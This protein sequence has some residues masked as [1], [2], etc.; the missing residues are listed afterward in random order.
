V[1]G[2]FYACRKPEVRLE[3]FMRKAIALGADPATWLKSQFV[4]MPG[5]RR[6]SGTLQAIYFLNPRVIR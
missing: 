2:W 3:H 6:L 4:R 1:H 5:G